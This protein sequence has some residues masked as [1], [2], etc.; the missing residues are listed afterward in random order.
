MDNLVKFPELDT[1][2]YIHYALDSKILAVA[3][4]VEKNNKP[5]EWSAY[6]GIVEGKDHNNEYLEVVKNGT[7]LS[8]AIA[9]SIWPIFEHIEWRQ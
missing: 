8:K 3:V 1:K 6:I 5:I 4:V 2:Q 9:L 7:K